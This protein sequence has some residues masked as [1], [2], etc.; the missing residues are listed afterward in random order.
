MK[1]WKA[2]KASGKSGAVF[3]QYCLNSSATGIRL[4][5]STVLSAVIGRESSSSKKRWG[6]SWSRIR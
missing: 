3:R 2:L 5:A 4:S 1:V 6:L